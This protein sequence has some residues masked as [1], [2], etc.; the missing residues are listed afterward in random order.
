MRRWTAPGWRLLLLGL[1]LLP[2]AGC[3]R[4]AEAVDGAPDVRAR[5]LPRPDTLVVSPLTLD[6]TLQ[7]AAGAAIDGATAVTL[8][9]DMA[10]AGM[11][12]VIATATG[13]GEGIYT[14]DFEWTM[15]GDWIVTV[16]ATLPD[17]RA[18]R[19]EFPFTVGN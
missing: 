17:G 1:L 15:A 7:D 14:A 11:Q 16:E 8:R 3:R 9:G 18:L 2:A 6:L 10:H 5:L 12:P 19:R 13:H 4:S